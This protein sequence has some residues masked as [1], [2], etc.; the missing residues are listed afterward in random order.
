MKRFVQIAI[1]LL[2]VVAIAVIVVAVAAPDAGATLGG[3][4]NVT[5]RLID[6]TGA[7]LPGG[8]VEYYRKGWHSLG[9]TDPNGEVKAILPPG[10]YAFAVTYEGTREQKDNIDITTTHTVIFQT[11]KMAVNLQ[12]CDGTGLPGGEAEYYAKGWHSMGDTDPSGS[13]S[14]EMLPGSYSF[15]M[16]YQGTRQQIDNV[17]ITTTNPLVFNTTGVTIYFSG[18]VKY[19]AKGWHD[20]TKPTTDM[21]PGTYWFS[22]DTK[23]K[24]Q[25]TVSGCD[26]ARV[27]NILRLTGHDGSP[28][29]G[30]TARVQYGQWWYHVNGQ[31]DDKGVLIDVREAQGGPPGDM[32]YEMTYN[33]TISLETH[34]AST[35]SYYDFKTNLL[36]LRLESSSGQP[37]D[38]GKARY[39]P[40]QWGYWFPGGPTGS[41]A[42]GE[43]AAEFFPGTYSFEM[44]Y[45]GTS[46][47]KDNV[48]VPD[49]DFTITWTTT[50]VT[51][52]FSKDITYTGSDGWEHAY[53]K[54][55]MELFPGTYI[56]DFKGCDSTDITV[57]A[58]AV[59]KSFVCAELLDSQGNGLAGGVF[60][61]RE[62][63]SFGPFTN[64]GTTD[65]DG[66][67]I[68]G[69][70][71]I[72]KQAKFR[73]TYKDGTT[74]ER[75]QDIAS[76]SFVVFQTVPVTAKLLSSDGST[77]LTANATFEYR[78][79]F[80]AYKP[81]TSPTELL[82]IQTRMRVS[83]EGGTTQDTVQ[84]VG[85]NPDFVWHTVPVT[86]KLIASDGTTNLSANATFEF[87]YGWEAYRTFTSPTELLPTITKMRVSYAGGTTQ[88]TVQDV[89]SNPNFVW[90][91]GEVT[92]TTCTFYRYFYGQYLTFTS[93]M[94]L[95]PLQTKFAAITDGQHD[96]IATPVSG[97]S[98]SVT[99]QP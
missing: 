47:R 99:C 66:K 53:T 25:L 39:W 15:A 52:Q 46:A 82:P 58:T 90:Q 93:P 96:T 85:A 95:L 37:L 97:S 3:D 63:S 38:G 56:F 70:D 88:D 65:A 13:A 29:E 79:N 68:Y 87:R 89:G 54:P 36:T 61:Y 75:S 55:T 23:Y 19:Y 92:S 83:Y 32:T 43:T 72:H 7:G 16:T 57:G 73:V 64:M 44:L 27:V 76:D 8:Q 31:T 78:Y 60:E 34:N 17:D 62:A 67:L 21:L 24:T 28:L 18:D 48:I 50:A 26:M 59:E 49:S 20:F 81:F 35:N 22:F 10:T 42:P 6:S 2:G 80:G 5:V 30:G 86:A 41:S 91:T 98:I 11:V 14:A 1:A 69:I 51:L 94:E 74:P 33:H 77:D 9:V 4:S 40:D 45:N 71:G 84:D 12:R